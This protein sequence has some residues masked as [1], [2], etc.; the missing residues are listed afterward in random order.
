MTFRCISFGGHRLYVSVLA[1]AAAG[2][3]LMGSLCWHEPE[4]EFE[5]ENISNNP[6]WSQRPCIACSDDGRV[7]L[8]WSDY[9]TGYE[10]VWLVE[11]EK[12][13]RWTEPVNLSKAGNANGSRSVTLCF[14]TDGTLHAAWSQAVQIGQSG[15][16]VWAIAYT[17][18]P[19][20]GEWAVPETIFHGTATRPHIAVDTSGT[21][22]LQF[23]DM[24]GGSHWTIC[25]ANRNPTGNWSPV[26]EVSAPW[27]A[28]DGDLAAIDDGTVVVAWDDWTSF[29]LRTLWSERIPSGEWSPPRVVYNSSNDCY[30]P[31]LASNG[32]VVAL[33]FGGSYY[34]ITVMTKQTGAAWSEPDTS[35]ETRNGGH[36]SIALSKQGHVFLGFANAAEPALR[37]ARRDTGWTQVKVTDS[38]F[39]SKTTLVVDGEGH[40]HL[41]WSSQPDYPEPGDIYYVEVGIVAFDGNRN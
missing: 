5:I 15:V 13:G 34:Y 11:K 40:V 22:H 35:C 32:S 2:L 4:P 12:G 33:A 30:V 20:G 36:R 19:S 28:G 26:Q 24:A 1:I 27:S 18:R 23:T 17:R 6:S 10:E 16:W 8:A 3:L 9:A 31:I 21:V 39:P 37:L 29:P 25:Y 7:V 14:G 38:L 41:A